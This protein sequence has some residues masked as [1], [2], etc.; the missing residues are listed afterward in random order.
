MLQQL[1]LLAWKPRGPFITGADERRL[2]PQM[3]RVFDCLKDGKERTLDQ[4]SRE[5]GDP[6]ASCS[7]RF[8]DL[9][10]LGFRTEHKNLGNGLWMYR[11]AV[12]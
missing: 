6:P 5:T 12:E 4:I 10:R 11:V 3:Q 8:R 9:K 2:A 1:D 7:A